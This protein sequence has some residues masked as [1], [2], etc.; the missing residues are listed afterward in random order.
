[1]AP[2]PY[3]PRRGRSPVRINVARRSRPPSRSRSRSV[4]LLPTRGYI[5]TAKRNRV[6]MVLRRRPMRKRVFKTVSGA[7]GQ[8][9]NFKLGRPMPT[10]AKTL[11]KGTNFKVHRSLVSSRLDCL[12]GQQAYTSIAILRNGGYAQVSNPDYEIPYLLNMASSNSLPNQP[13]TNGSPSTTQKVFLHKIFSKFMMTNMD[14]GNLQLHIF[15]VITKRDYPTGASTAFDG[16]I[17]DISNSTQTGNALGLMPWSSPEFNAHFRVLQ[18]SSIIL[19]QGQS[20][21]HFVSYKPNKMITAERLVS[22]DISLA[23]YTVHTFI[24]IHGLPVNDRDNKT[25]VSTGSVSLDIVQTKEIHWSWMEHNKSLWTTTTALPLLSNEYE[26]NIG[27]GQ[28]A[29]DTEA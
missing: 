17:A 24:V 20:H 7:G 11:L 9:S 21:T 28:P 4:S 10:Y 25:Q 19:A 29:L 18:K 12:Q 27:S 16:G 22:S 3:V 15:D 1:M 6:N 5:P 8:T 2:L 23:G 13:I 26:I 14:I